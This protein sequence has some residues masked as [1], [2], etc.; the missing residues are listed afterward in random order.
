MIRALFCVALLACGSPPV[1][2]DVK[3]PQASGQLALAR[4]VV[5]PGGGSEL[6]IKLTSSEG[7]P[8]QRVDASDIR[9]TLA[10]EFADTTVSAVEPLAMSVGISA[11]LVVPAETA[12]LRANQAETLKSFIRERP[13]EEAIGVFLWRDDVAQLANF[14]TDREHLDSQLSKL[15]SMES[16]SE[17]LATEDAIVAVEAIVMS[18]GGRAPRGLRSL[19]I[20]GSAVTEVPPTRVAVA[21]GLE[22]ASETIEAFANSSYY[23]VSVCG[24][25][26]G[27]EAQLDVVDLEG[28]LPVALAPSLPESATAPCNIAAMGEGLRSYPEALELVFSESQRQVYNERVAALSKADFGLSV[29]LDD[30]VEISASAHLRGKGTLGCERKSY[31]L[32]LYGPG[33]H[34]MPASRTDEFYLLSMCADDRYVQQYTANQLMKELGL[35][36]LGFRF[37]EVTL[38][39][40]K[41]GV[42]LLLEKPREE[43]VSDG[44]NIHNVMRRRFNTNPPEDFFESKFDS[45]VFDAADLYARA[46]SNVTLLAEQIDVE[47][48]LRFLA[49]MTAYQNGDFIDE[50]WVTASE[51]RLSDDTA[52]LWFETMAWDNDD[53]FSE[54]HYNGRFAFADS[55]EL[56]Y[57]AEAAIDYSLLGDAEVYAHYVDVLEAVLQEVTPERFDAAVGNT[58]QAIM[59]ILSRPGVSAA[60]VRLVADNPEAIEPGEAQRDVAVKLGELSSQYR[61]RHAV[62]L[63]R[64]SSYREAL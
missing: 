1:D 10:G 32:E 18:A 45:G 14:T 15:P 56:V 63:E 31:T 41:Q 48:Y 11:L 64:I 59:P 13:A 12:S 22:H 37:I 40:D 21:V 16:A 19:V 17:I 55:N 26:A 24:S 8:L 50:I 27:G 2:A 51:Q 9:I 43:L 35:F 39:G 25:V 7:L 44:A 46:S 33:R 4:Q 49:L 60:M 61:A 52:G 29:R 5:W 28:T 20:A 53:L 30:G 58:E 6:T 38:D 54:C 23:R 36:P 47:Q 42:Y 34:L 3:L 62:L 57:C